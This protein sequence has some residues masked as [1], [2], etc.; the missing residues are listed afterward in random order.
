MSP[1]EKKAY[2]RQWYLAHQEDQKELARQWRK[3]NPESHREEVRQH[4]RKKREHLRQIRKE[5]GCKNCGNADP[6]VLDFH[7]RNPID[8][9]FNISG[10]ISK[11]LSTL[12]KEVEKCDVM[13]ANC[14]RIVEWEKEHRDDAS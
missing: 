2:A 7:H 9:S 4:L 14:H 1:E 13:C 8:K 12:L 10:H 5:L 3:A 6:R 11:G